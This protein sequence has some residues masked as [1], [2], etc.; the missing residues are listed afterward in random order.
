MIIKILYPLTKD[1]FLDWDKC[2]Q[3]Y[4]IENQINLEIF[5]NSDFYDLDIYVK[6][7]KQ[8]LE[9]L[10]VSVA[11]GYASAK[12]GKLLNI[13]KKK[14]SKKEMDKMAEDLKKKFNL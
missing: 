13:F 5:Y 8:K 12:K 4:V 3:Y 10:K 2:I 14:R 11:Y 1:G 7:Y 6:Q 9:D